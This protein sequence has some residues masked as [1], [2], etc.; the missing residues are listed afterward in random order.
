MVDT[1][2][3]PADAPDAL[4]PDERTQTHFRHFVM[5]AKRVVFFVACA[6]FCLWQIAFLIFSLFIVLPH[7]LPE[8]WISYRY[9]DLPLLFLVLVLSFLFLPIVCLGV[10][11][12]LFMTGG[13]ERYWQILKFFYGVELPALFLLGLYLINLRDYA[14]GMS[15]LLINAAIALCFWCVLIFYDRKRGHGAPKVLFVDSPIAMAGSTIVFAIGV[16]VSLGLLL[17]IV[18][19]LTVFSVVVFE[20]VLEL[21]KQGFYLDELWGVFIS[22]GFISHAL[23]WLAVCFTVCIDLSVYRSIYCSPASIEVNTISDGRCVSVGCAC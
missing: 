9:F 13:K 16:F 4:R 20:A 12:W 14:L 8:I 21:I 3:I 11:V 23:F 10:V 7:L 6:V 22:I 5:L 17:F 2:S 19:S 15:W 1:E 18:P